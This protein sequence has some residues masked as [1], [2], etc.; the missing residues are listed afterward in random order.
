[1]MF[2][3]IHIRSLVTAGWTFEAIDATELELAFI[4]T[5]EKVIRG[6]KLETALYDDRKSIQNFCSPQSI[7]YTTNNEPSIETLFKNIVTTL[8]T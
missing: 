8:N 6:L 1:M 7:P 4:E 3:F 5:G 2:S